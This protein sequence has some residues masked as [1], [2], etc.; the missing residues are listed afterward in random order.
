MHITEKLSLKM[1]RPFIST[2]CIYIQSIDISIDNDCNSPNITVSFIYDYDKYDMFLLTLLFTN[3]SSFFWERDSPSFNLG[4]LLFY[5]E[6]DGSPL[7]IADELGGFKLVCQ[8]VELISLKETSQDW[9]YL[10]DA[11]RL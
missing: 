6:E 2:K 1:K 11:M 9:V 7:V 3:V 4:E 5:D 10:M 8:D